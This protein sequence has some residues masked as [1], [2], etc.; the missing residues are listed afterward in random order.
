MEN[1]SSAEKTHLASIHVAENYT[2]SLTLGSIDD[3]TENFN[4]MKSFNQL[5]HNKNTYSYVIPINQK[6][7]D[8]IS[9]VISNKSY[10]DNDKLSWL[11][12]NNVALCGSS[13]HRKNNP[14][15][16]INYDSDEDSTSFKSTKD[17]QENIRQL[18]SES[19]D[20]KEDWVSINDNTPL[21]FD[22]SSNIRK[23]N[24]YQWTKLDT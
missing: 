12:N 20:E 9:P 2:Q 15:L 8:E 13:C 18:N 1:I 4:L 14:T 3:V 11:H 22:K 21:L 23:R 7:Y 16:T 17:I 10:S 19:A 24:G 5:K 6:F